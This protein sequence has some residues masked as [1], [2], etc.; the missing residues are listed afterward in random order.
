M[1][2]IEWW[3]L[4]RDTLIS[5]SSKFI[6]DEEKSRMGR[7]LHSED[8]GIPVPK[9]KTLKVALMCPTFFAERYSSGNLNATTGGVENFLL[10]I[11]NI[12]SSVYVFISGTL[13]PLLKQKICLFAI[14]IFQIAAGL[15]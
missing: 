8:S 2:V 6:T 3:P 9:F 14:A 12:V 4:Q 15:L 11:A 13:C 7:S 10:M 1:A 5:I